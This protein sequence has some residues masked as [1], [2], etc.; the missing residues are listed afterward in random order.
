MMQTGEI[1]GNHIRRLFV[2]EALSIIFKRR[3][4]PKQ[5]AAA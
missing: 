1:E 4:S 2:P 5:S 3:D